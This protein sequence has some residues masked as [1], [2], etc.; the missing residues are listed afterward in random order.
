MLLIIAREVVKKR[1][2]RR[3]STITT[4]MGSA[5]TKQLRIVPVM[6]V[7]SCSHPQLD[8]TFAA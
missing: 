7:P 6:E 5:L 1:K 3:W 8:L 4:I 2:R